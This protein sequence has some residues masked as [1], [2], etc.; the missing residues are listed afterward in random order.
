MPKLKR[1]TFCLLFLSTV[2]DGSLGSLLGDARGTA[3]DD[4]GGLTGRDQICSKTGPAVVT[5]IAFC[6]RPRGWAATCRQAGE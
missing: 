4:V 1:S 2:E 6:S 5:A 3:V